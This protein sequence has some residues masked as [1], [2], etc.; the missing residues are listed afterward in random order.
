MKRIILILIIPFI[1]SSCLR[2]DDN[3][4]NP[5]VLDEYKLDQFEGD[6]DFRLGSEY[7]I[8]DSLV[9]VFTLNSG[10]N[11]IYA[12]YI[13]D[14]ARINSDTVI[15]YCHGNGRHIDFFW[16]R[17]KILANVGNKNRFGVLMMDYRGYGLSKGIPTEEGLYED[18]DA[19]FNWLKEKGLEN[20]RLAVYGF[21]M[22]TAPATKLA[23]NARSMR[24]SWLI[25]E[26][27]FASAEVMA[28]DA[29]ILAIPGSFF[30]NLKIDNAEQIKK[31]QQPFLWIHGY[32]DDYLSIHTHGEVVFKNYKGTD[33]RASRISNAGHSN[34]P[35][36]WGFKEY[37]DAIAIF[38][39][40]I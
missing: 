23:G 2:L 35:N 20:S 38:L 36:T 15:V 39:G 7:D 5:I 25:L 18:V 1:L 34:I 28:Q 37:T 26:A 10:G 11:K 31:V 16:P 9:H 6:V 29:A 8:P 17:A 21:S 22:G 14:T 30:V 33:G 13:G 12:V 19:C 24:P 32:M 4:F 3:L 27:P 40:G